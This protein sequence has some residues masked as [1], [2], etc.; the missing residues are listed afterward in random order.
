MIEALWL[1]LS[2]EGEWIEMGDERGMYE[3]RGGIIGQTKR[4][5]VGDCHQ[6]EGW[7]LLLE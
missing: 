2:L 4:E 1:Y 6:F 3:L 7:L 5:K